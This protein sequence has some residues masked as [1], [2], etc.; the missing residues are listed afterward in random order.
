MHPPVDVYVVLVGADYR[1]TN[2]ADV[3]PAKLLLFPT[4]LVV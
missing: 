3:S 2:I 1:I 4:K